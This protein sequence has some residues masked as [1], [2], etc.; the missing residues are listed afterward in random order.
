MNKREFSRFD[1]IHL[2]FCS[3]SGAD[4]NPFWE[5]MARTL[6]I[7]AGGVLIQIDKLPA[8]PI[9]G[10]KMEIALDEKIIELEGDVVFSRIVD[11]DRKELGVQF[12]GL[13]VE[14]NSDLSEFLRIF[15]AEGDKKRSLL[16]ESVTNINNVVMTLSKEHK[17]INDY[18]AECRNMLEKTKKDNN[19]G[20]YEVFFYFMKK[21]LKDH[22]RFEEEVLF[23][24][25]LT[26]KEDRAL[27]D[28]VRKLREDHSRIEDRIDNLIEK[29]KTMI[30]GNIGVEHALDGLTDELVREI[31]DHAKAEVVHLFPAIDSDRGKLKTLNQLLIGRA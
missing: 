27:I 24:A 5:G 19:P 15:E 8:D 16:R 20:N 2:V 10:M 29:M 25:A 7:S 21:D 30:K 13:S 6:N 22:F 12:T 26:G 1:S 17:V 4:G 11:A 23:P 31:K 28:L 14:K 18:V 3:F 9:A